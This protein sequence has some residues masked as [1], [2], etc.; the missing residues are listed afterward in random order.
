MNAQALS[1]KAE[2]I[3]SVLRYMD[4]FKDTAGVIYLDGRVIDSPLFASVV[5]DI[6][7]LHQTG[8]QVVVVPGARRRIDE[9]LAES[10]IAW[11]TERGARITEEGAM[12]LIKM[13]A[14]DVSNRVMTS[15]AG[16]RCTAVIGNWVRARG[17][18]IIEGVDYGTAGE[19]DRI[20]A[21]AVRTVLSSG[22][23]PIFPC[24]GWSAGGKP[25]NISSV[26]LA[27]EVAAEL[28]APKL[29]FVAPDAE[30]SRKRFAVPPSVGTEGER[31]P[32]LSVEEAEALI[33]Q[34][35]GTAE[36]E[37]QEMLELLDAGR[38]AC[39][40]GVERAHILNG[41]LD[42]ALPCEV[43]SDFG[44]GTMLYKSGYGGIRSMTLDDIPAVL[45]VMLPFA[46][47]GILL[48]RTQAGIAAEYRDYIVFELD[49]QIRACAALH[50]YDGAQ[51][52]I[53]AIAVDESFS[54]MGTGPKLVAFLVD[55]ARQRKAESVFALTTQTADWFEQLG[56]VPAGIG[57]LPEKRRAEWTPERGSRAYRLTL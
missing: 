5:R 7:L 47:R 4:R 2:N 27:T 48:P 51:C 43:F 20:Y 52:E 16:E 37:A 17:R 11:R 13:A 56:F 30:V 14:F 39:N 53:A 21:D 34:N 32:A 6:R 57:T 9:I 19:I 45:G 26:R 1:A 29:F 46:E 10:G 25:Y 31:V 28:R 38:E 15:L 54:H 42:G 55:R 24:I 33:G 44:S 12:P 18:G 35:R 40:R 50:F 3:R 23:I 8:M 41:S 22:F 36:E 49:G